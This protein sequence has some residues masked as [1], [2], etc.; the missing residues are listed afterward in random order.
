MGIEVVWAIFRP[1]SP[2]K[3]LK[4][5]LLCSFYSP[6]LAGKNAK[7]VDHLTDEVQKFLAL[8][9]DG[10]IIVSGDANLLDIDALLEADSSLKQIVK[11]PT[12]K[13]KTL[14]IV[15]TNL[16]KYFKPPMSIPPLNPDDPQTA[17]PGDHLVLLVLP[18]SNQMGLRNE[19]QVS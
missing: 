6:P 19:T 16:G 14:D 2:S 9:P 3:S 10:G 4:K 13:D 18:V 12:R 11:V 8:N 17:H 15:V 5:I 7:L 1:I